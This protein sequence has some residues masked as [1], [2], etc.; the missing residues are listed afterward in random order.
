MVDEKGTKCNLNSKEIK[1]IIAFATIELSIYLKLKCCLLVCLFVHHANYSPGTAGI[2]YFKF[3]IPHDL[4][5]IL[6]VCAFISQ[7]LINC[8]H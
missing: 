2:V 6:L 8:Q 3:A 1:P 7:F 4:E 5:N